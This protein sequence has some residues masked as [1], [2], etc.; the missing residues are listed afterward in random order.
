MW[1]FTDAA[2]IQAAFAD[3]EFM[4]QARKR[5]I[6]KGVPVAVF[7]A[8]SGGIAG[9]LLLAAPKHV[10]AKLAAGGGEI[11]IQSALGASGEAAGQLV[12]KGEITSPPDILA[13]AIAE[14][15]PGAAQVGI[16]AALQRPPGG[17]AAP[18]APQ[19]PRRWTRL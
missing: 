17:Q 3:T 6:R 11:A 9:R 8:I 18:V 13:E 5:A 10:A 19:P 1:T 14:L 4:E 12:E 2:Q 7:D 15:G 16:G